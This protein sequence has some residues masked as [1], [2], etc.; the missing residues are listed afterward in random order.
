MAYT[1]SQIVDKWMEPGFKFFVNR[2]PAGTKGRADFL[3]RESRMKDEHLG[4][5]LDY[6]RW[7]GE[8]TVMYE[9][10]TKKLISFIQ[11]WMRLNKD[12]L[13]WADTPPSANFTLPYTKHDKCP[14]NKKHT[15]LVRDLGGRIRCAHKSQEKLK[16]RFMSS[17]TTFDELSY[18]ALG[19]KQKII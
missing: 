14:R 3:M 4:A 18:L 19:I 10:G 5:C 16:P 2:E 12:N 13:I 8:T 7:G 9:F 6:I 15:G 11:N 1:S 17:Y